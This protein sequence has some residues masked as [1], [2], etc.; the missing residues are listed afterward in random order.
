MRQLQLEVAQGRFRTGSNSDRL[1]RWVGIRQ[2]FQ[3]TFVETVGHER[4]IRRQLPPPAGAVATRQKGQGGCVE[5][6]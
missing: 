4:S 1:R 2:G 6:V 5:L 3:Q